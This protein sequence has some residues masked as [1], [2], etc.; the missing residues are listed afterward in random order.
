M[1]PRI[2]RDA[3]IE[4]IEP[5]H[6]RLSIAGGPGG[7]YRLAQLDDYTHLNRPAFAWQAPCSLEIRGRVSAPDL[8]GTW[9]F[10]FWNDPFSA[11][12]GFS[13][14][15]RRLP[16]LPIAAWFFY[17]SPPNFLSLKDASP[18]Q[19]FLA[20]AFS[21]PLIPPVLLA[22]GL[23]GLPLLALPPAARL[24]RRLGR[25]LVKDQAK[26]L[27]VDPTGWHIYRIDVQPDGS[28]FYVD[29][30]EVFVTALAQ[31]G[32]L[33]RV[34]WIDNQYAAFSPDGMVKFGSLANPPAWLE[35]EILG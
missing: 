27:S 1:K 34:I 14:M 9:G 10:G 26:T 29:G 24:L 4:T 22:P 32:R 15:G 25:R 6:F 5:G 18:A 19:G 7:I 3:G 21:S 28:H 20:S 23:L 35:V 30:V 13:G 16:A 33:G 12:L 17:G 8:P 31:R 2:T 11:N